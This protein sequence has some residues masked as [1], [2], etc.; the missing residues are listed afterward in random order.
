M[1][2]KC[3]IA[4]EIGDTKFTI[5]IAKDIRTILKKKVFPTRNPVDSLQ[6][7]VNFFKNEMPDCETK[8]EAIVIDGR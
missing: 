5:L 3:Y 8:L 1:T 6:D 7:I 2:K 4:E